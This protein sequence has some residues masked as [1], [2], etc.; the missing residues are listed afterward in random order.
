MSLENDIVVAHSLIS[1]RLFS[2]PSKTPI[3]YVLIK[4]KKSAKKRELIQASTAGEAIEKMLEQKK[5]SSKINYNVLRDLNSKG[6]STPKKDDDTT[7]DSTSTKKLSR[8][9]SLVNRNVA[10]SV[11]PV[12]KRYH[13]F[14][15]NFAL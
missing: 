3:P 8:R 10:N 7:D 14:F 13:K 4:P 5:I 2:L 1:A 6:G 11:N 9:K 15:F 12:G